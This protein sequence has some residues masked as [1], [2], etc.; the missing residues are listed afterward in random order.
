[1]IKRSEEISKLLFRR[2]LVLYQLVEN[3]GLGKERHFFGDN[4]RKD[5]SNNGLLEC[6]L[7]WDNQNVRLIEN[8][9]LMCNVLG[10]TKTTSIFFNKFQIMS[11]WNISL[12]IALNSS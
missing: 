4:S 5:D 11:K 12:C 2:S 7:S 8:I 3:G 9:A 10:F 6:K 1:M